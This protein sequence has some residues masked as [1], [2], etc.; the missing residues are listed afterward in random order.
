MTLFFTDIV[1]CELFDVAR[2]G[3]FS[4]V[5]FLLAKFFVES[6][7]TLVAVVVCLLDEYII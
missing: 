2:I 5:C 1:E 4:I 3:I 6:G 7:K